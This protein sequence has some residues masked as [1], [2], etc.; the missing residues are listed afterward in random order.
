MAE[1]NPMTTILS[2]LEGKG[3]STGAL[4]LDAWQPTINITKNI[5]LLETNGITHLNRLFIIDHSGF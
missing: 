1:L 2:I 4:P 5:K 3:F